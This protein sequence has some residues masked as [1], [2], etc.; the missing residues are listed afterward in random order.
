MFLGSAMPDFEFS[1]HARDM[2]VERNIVEAWVWRTLT[3]PD[4]KEHSEDNNMHYAKAI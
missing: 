1:S 2:L 3:D 4:K